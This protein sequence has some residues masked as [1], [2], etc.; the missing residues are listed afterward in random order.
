MADP[1]L[2]EL[3]A[4]LGGVRGCCHSLVGSP[5]GGQPDG[6]AVEVYYDSDFARLAAAGG[7]PHEWVVPEGSV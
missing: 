1:D 3:V 7:A 4:A 6:A 2:V 5:W